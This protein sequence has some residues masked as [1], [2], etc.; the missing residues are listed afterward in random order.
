MA[1]A[2]LLGLLALNAL[3]AMSELAIMTARRSRLQQAADA[4]GRGAAT[5]LALAR[6]PTRFL[7]TV[8]GGITLVGILSGAFAERAVSSQLQDAIA[9]V[10]LL[11]P[12]AATLALAVVVLGV[13]YFSLVLGELV[14]KRLALAHPEAVASAISRPLDLASRIAAWPI[15]VLTLSTDGVLRLLR[16]RAREGDDVSEEDVK[17]L[18][19]RAATTG[20]FDPLEHELFQRVFRVG[21][22]SARSLMVPRADMTWIDESASVDEVRVLVGTSPFSHFPVCRGNVDDIVGVVH[23]KDLIAHGLVAGADFNVARVAQ[24]AMFVPETTAALKLLDRFQRTKTHIA[25]V[26]DEYGGTEGLVT[27]ND[28]IR[29]IVGDIT[30]SGEEPP[31]KAVRRDDGSLLLD[32]R[33]PLHELL[34]VL[35]LS[36]RAADELPA[37]HTAAGLVVALLGNVPRV[38]QHVD[39]NGWRLEVVDMDDHRID[40]ILAR[41]P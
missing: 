25:F 15:R 29:A 9:G 13:T 18:V 31:P 24:R 8:Q 20:V 39:W 27:L 10:P 12:Y 17:S 6:E 32:G 26:V 4:G 2:I 7:S 33:L 21:D 36:D 1:L 28:V 16:V 11:A 38:G 23:V 30:R 35:A 40:Q 5:A 14:P 22:L 34:G 41:R 19:A 3:F 37:V